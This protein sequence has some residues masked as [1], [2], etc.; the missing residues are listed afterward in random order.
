MVDSACHCI[1]SKHRKIDQRNILFFKKKKKVGEFWMSIG[2]SAVFIRNTSF[3]SD[4]H[5]YFSIALYGFLSFFLVH[6]SI[7]EQIHMCDFF[8]FHVETAGKAW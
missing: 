6:A 2:T 4:A 5:Q 8:F 1:I 3:T 7:W